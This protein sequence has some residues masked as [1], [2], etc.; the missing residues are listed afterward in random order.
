MIREGMY[1]DLEHDGRMMQ[2]FLLPRQ[3][4]RSA[5]RCENRPSALNL[6][7]SQANWSVTQRYDLLVLELL[8]LPGK[9]YN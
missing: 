2:A 6:T 9:R 7:C 3:Y 1:I 4:H 5:P 8:V